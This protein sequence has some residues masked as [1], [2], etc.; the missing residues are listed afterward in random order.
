M[1]PA[2]DL[3]QKIEQI[4][5]K[6]YSPVEVARVNDQVIRM[7]L[8]DGEFHWHKHTNEDELFFVYKGEIIIQYRDRQNVRLK[9]GQMHVVPKGIEHCPKSM[10][11][12]YILLFEPYQVNPRGD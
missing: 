10:E 1:I 2:I 7:A 3:E 5:G 12:S 4:D 9:A 6:P 8:A 11:P